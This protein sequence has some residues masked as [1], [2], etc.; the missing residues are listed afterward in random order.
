M[1]RRICSRTAL[2]VA[3]TIPGSLAD[4]RLSTATDYRK[5]IDPLLGVSDFGIHYYDDGAADATVLFP[6]NDKSPW[7]RPRDAVIAL[8]RLGPKGLPVLIDC[9]DDTTITSVRF[10]GNRITRPMNVPLGYICLDILMGVARGKPVSDA[11]CSDDGLG[12]CMND[13]F[14]FRPDD[15]ENCWA[16][17]GTCGLRPWVR[18]VQANWRREFL[19]KRLRF[20]NPYDDAILEE[21]KEFTTPKRGR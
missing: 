8:V 21:Y 15:Y 3:I 2:I 17:T 10:D 12:A 18:V 11:E 20:R 4:Q 1:A 6:S 13:G 7:D 14:Y 9:L 5:Y 16:Q 19:K